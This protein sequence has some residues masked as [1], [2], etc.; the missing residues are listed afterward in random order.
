MIKRKKIIS[1]LRIESF[2]FAKIKFELPLSKDAL[3]QVCLVLENKILN[4][5]DVYVL[6]RYYLFLENGLVLNF[7]K[8]PL[9]KDALRQV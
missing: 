1:A 2:L 6:V 5:A 7:N 3:C 9:P 4:V 8:C